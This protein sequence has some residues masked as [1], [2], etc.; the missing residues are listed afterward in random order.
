M[1][2]TEF[3]EFKVH[4]HVREMGATALLEFYIKF[5]TTTSISGQ[6]LYIEL[7]TRLD[8]TRV[9]LDD[10][11]LNLRQNDQVTCDFLVKTNYIGPCNSLFLYFM[12][13]I[14]CRYLSLG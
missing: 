10:L 5:S 12:L 8:D 2:P 3:A 4:Q 11:G 7:P 1:L 13:F 6:N 9:F 14:F